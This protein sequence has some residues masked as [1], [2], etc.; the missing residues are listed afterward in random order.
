MTLDNNWLRES[1]RLASTLVTSP[2]RLGLAATLLVLLALMIPPTGILNDNEEHYFAAALHY[3]DPQADPQ[4]SAVMGGLPHA[5]AFA[6]IA[7]PLARDLGFEAASIIG[8]SLTIALY[9]L[10]L[11]SLFSRLSM[12]PVDAVLVL[13]AFYLL[14]QETIGGEW[15]FRGF[16]PKVLAYPFVILALSDMV[17]GR[18]RRAFLLLAIATWFHFLVGGFWAALFLLAMWLSGIRDRRLTYSAGS[19]A[20]LVAPILWL[21]VSFGY[22]QSHEASSGTL[23]SAAWII[24]HFRSAH[25]ATPF[26]SLSELLDW[27]PGVLLTVALGILACLLALSANGPLRLLAIMVSA[28]CAYLVLMFVATGFDSAGL[29]GPYV[30]FRPSSLLLL[31]ALITVVIWLQRLG[32][33]GLIARSSAALIIMTGALPAWTYDV[34][35]PVRSSRTLATEVEPIVE[36]AKQHTPRHATFLIEPSIERAFL[37]FE[38]HTHRRVL[39]MHK[40]V[41]AASNEIQ[42]WY[43]RRLFQDRLFES[44]CTAAGG[45]YEV[46]FLITSIATAERLSEDCGRSALRSGRFALIIVTS[47]AH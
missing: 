36:Y 18:H 29:L 6:W 2:S 26:G 17:A 32:P 33:D 31:V 9:G 34:V 19:Y 43:R 20:V 21:L 35:T 38:R 12:R 7:G 13:G 3:V 44:G 30:V 46:D 40:F 37:G 41:P 27:S 11:L 23:P 25:H 16:E 14:G 42:E 45:Q 24:S 39:V 4:G 8:R 10:A 47:S 28:G 22:G 5:F 15:L 1:A